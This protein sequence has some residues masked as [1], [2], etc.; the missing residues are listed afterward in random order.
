MLDRR[1]SI[2]NFSMEVHIDAKRAVR[3]QFQCKI[4]VP[5]FIESQ[6]PLEVR[7]ANN[8]PRIRQPI[9]VGE[10]E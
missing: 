10:T 6:L 3:S 1:L 7:L 4:Q 8:E 9:R 2:T 5:I